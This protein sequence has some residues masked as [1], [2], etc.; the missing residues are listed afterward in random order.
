MSNYFS[1]KALSQSAIKAYLRSPKHY[2]AFMQG[3]NKPT[4]SM[5]LGTAIHCA[6]LEPEKFAE[7]YTAGRQ[8]AAKKAELA[9]DG[10]VLISVADY[11]KCVA[12]QEAIAN[13][14]L[15][16]RSFFTAQALKNSKV[17]AELFYKYGNFGI[18]CKAKL[19]L[20]TDTYVLDIKTCQNAHPDK[21]GREIKK[22]GYDLQAAFYLD[23]LD[24]LFFP[25]NRHYYILAIETNAPHYMCLYKLSDST[26]YEGRRKYHDAMWDIVSDIEQPEN[27]TAGYEFYAP[28][29][30]YFEI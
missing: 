15:H 8:T 21:F 30:M 25:E 20:Y 17:E 1:S 19:D 4:K 3:E 6:I 5:E 24:T 10:K 11:R 26:I 28:N 29:G 27:I 22:Y 23:A 7:T 13:A 9:L 14:P 12:I 2:A 16:I 18:D